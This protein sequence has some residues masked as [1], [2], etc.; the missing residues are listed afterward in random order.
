VT[1]SISGLRR[2]RNSNIIGFE[3]NEPVASRRVDPSGILG[4]ILG[5][6]LWRVFISPRHWR[7]TGEDGLRQIVLGEVVVIR[8]TAGRIKQISVRFGL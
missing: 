5:L 2:R 7:E 6:V 8:H 1:G 4:G 3:D